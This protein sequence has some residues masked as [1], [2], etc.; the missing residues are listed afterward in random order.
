MGELRGERKIMRIMEGKKGLGGLCGA[1][2]REREPYNRAHGQNF[3]FR[4]D[5]KL[6]QASATAYTF[7]FCSWNNTPRTVATKWNNN[8]DIEGGRGE[9]ERERE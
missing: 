8:D 4:N 2:G 6:G 7:L 5:L 3:C 9:R 1:K